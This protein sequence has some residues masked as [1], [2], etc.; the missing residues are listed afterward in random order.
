MSLPVQITF[1]GIEPSAAIEAKIREKVEGLDACYS[2]ITRCRVV[3]ETP[4]R[5][6]QHGKLYHVRIDIA[7]PDAELVVSRNPQEHQAH[8]DVFIAIRDAF[9][10]ARRQLEEYA[11]RRRG[12]T[13]AHEAEAS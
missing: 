4:H 6:Q 5:H 12:E 2:R 13:K 10:A 9:H 7:V 1:R 3:V 8:Q 11:R